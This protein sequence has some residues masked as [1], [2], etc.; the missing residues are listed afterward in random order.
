MKEVY[1]L[2]KEFKRKYPL[3]VAWRLRSHSKVI[4]KHL[5][6]DEKILYVFMGQK[7]HSSFDFVNTNLIVLTSKRLMIATKRLLFGYFF[8]AVTPDMF[9]DLTV[10]DGII[11][12]RIK[13]DT[14]KEEVLLS[15]IDPKALPE[16]ESQVSNYM[17]QEKRKYAQK[18][19][20]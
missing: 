17:I 9:N 11:W 14:V 13:I 6:P 12:G 7:N 16:I 19:T 8:I 15:N 10:I 5:N 2:A 20:K 4:A 3:T 1:R 18:I